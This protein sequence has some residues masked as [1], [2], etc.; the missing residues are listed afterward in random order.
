[1]SQV[2][3]SPF[4]SDEENWDAEKLVNCLKIMHLIQVNLVSAS[5]T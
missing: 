2:V 4:F 3:F 1:M 5:K